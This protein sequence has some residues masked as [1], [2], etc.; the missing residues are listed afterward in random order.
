MYDNKRHA[1]DTM[2]TN[3]AGFDLKHIFGV[4]LHHK[5]IS[6]TLKLM[7]PQSNCLPLAVSVPNLLRCSNPYLGTQDNGLV[8]FL[9]HQITKE[10]V[11]HVVFRHN[12]IPGR[13]VSLAD[14]DPVCFRDGT[15]PPMV[16]L[17]LVVTSVS[18]SYSTC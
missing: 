13:R 1:H 18:C 5:V 14:L 16:T 4:A 17:S 3:R 10:L 12:H 2:M 6:I 7:R 11:Y 9:N 15:H 8:W